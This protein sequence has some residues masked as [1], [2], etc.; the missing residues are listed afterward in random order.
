MASSCSPRSNKSASANLA[1]IFLPIIA[2]LVTRGTSLNP[3]STSG[4]LPENGPLDIAVLPEWE[5]SYSAKKYLPVCGD[6][7]EVP[8]AGFWT[9]CPEC[10]PSL[11]SFS[12]SSRL[13]AVFDLSGRLASDSIASGQKTCL[14]F[15]VKHSG[16]STLDICL[17]VDEQGDA[18]VREEFGVNVGVGLQSPRR[19]GRS[20][21]PECKDYVDASDS[22]NMPSGPSSGDLNSSQVKEDAKGGLSTE[23][24]I[25]LGTG[26]PG[27]IVAVVTILGFCC[28]PKLRNKC[29]GRGR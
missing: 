21:L 26:I 6:S 9:N 25:A 22:S 15:A 17:L 23:A 1:K 19:S 27:G 29:L 12:S 5:I 10:E 3:L 7:R 4:P 14:C 16:G 20:T 8:T 11:A 24:K 28:S 18:L 2:L 13:A